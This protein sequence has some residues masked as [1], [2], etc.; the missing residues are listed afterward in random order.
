MS[1]KARYLAITFWAI[2]EA[3]GRLKYIKEHKNTSVVKIHELREY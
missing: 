2:K 1:Y 3:Y